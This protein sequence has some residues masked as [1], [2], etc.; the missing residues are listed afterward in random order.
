VSVGEDYDLIDSWMLSLR[1]S[2]AIVQTKK[3]MG[4][5]IRSLISLC[6]DLE[7]DITN[8]TSKLSYYVNPPNYITA[9]Y[10]HRD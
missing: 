10:F 5:F 3:E 4:K 9:L 1:Y 2:E 7:N 6:K 8:Y